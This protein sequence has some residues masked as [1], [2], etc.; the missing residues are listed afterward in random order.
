[1]LCTDGLEVP[2]KSGFMGLAEKLV[3]KG[4]G[5]RGISWDPEGIATVQTLLAVGRH[6]E[7]QAP[8]G[9]PSSC[10]TA[11]MCPDVF[12]DCLPVLL[13]SQKNWGQI[14]PSSTCPEELGDIQIWAD[15]PNPLENA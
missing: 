6:R 5:S 11:Q 1:M 15:C 2:W 4:D 14:S 13:A 3:L 8:F 7:H 12:G 9:I 10:F